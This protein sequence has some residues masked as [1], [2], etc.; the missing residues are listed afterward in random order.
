MIDYIKY[1]GIVLRKNKCEKSRRKF[2]PVG[3][4]RKL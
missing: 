1:T 2:A 4:R 3:A